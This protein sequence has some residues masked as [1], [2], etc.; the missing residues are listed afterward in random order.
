MITIHTF[1]PNHSQQQVFFVFVERVPRGITLLGGE[2][3]PGIGRLSW[4]AG[5]RGHRCCCIL[6]KNVGKIMEDLYICIIL[7]I[8]YIY[9]KI[10]M[11][12]FIPTLR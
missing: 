7:Y 10:W 5:T 12:C 11:L 8:Y 4:Q 6:S 9:M 1:T 3:H 2:A